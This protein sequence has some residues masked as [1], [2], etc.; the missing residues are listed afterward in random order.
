MGNSLIRNSTPEVRAAREHARWSWAPMA[1]SIWRLGR[2]WHLWCSLQS[3]D[4]WSRLLGRWGWSGP[5]FWELEQKSRWWV[6]VVGW[7]GIQLRDQ[8]LPHSLGHLDFGV[9]MNSTL[10]LQVELG[11]LIATGSVLSSLRWRASDYRE[12]VSATGLSW[13]KTRMNS[14]CRVPP[15]IQEPFHGLGAPQS[16]GTESKVLMSGRPAWYLLDIWLGALDK[17]FTSLSLIVSIL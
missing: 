17:Q 1:A 13:G 2:A 15:E 11:S 16:T 9:Y 3:E 4:S 7:G 6:S 14:Y 8:Q 10:P 12:L 5:L